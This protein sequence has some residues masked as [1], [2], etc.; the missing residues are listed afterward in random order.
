MSTTVRRVLLVVGLVVLPWVVVP[1]LLARRLLTADEDLT[2]YDRDEVELMEPPGPHG[3]AHLAAVR[4]LRSAHDGFA[5]SGSPSSSARVA[6]VREWMDSLGR[7]VESDAEIRAVDADGVRGEW[8]LAPGHDPDVRLL[9]VHGGAFQAGT[10][11]S[12]RGL[13]TA[14]AERTGASVLAVEYRLQPE[15]RRRAAVHDV[16]AAWRW[17]I[18]TGPAAPGPAERATAAGDSAGANLVLGLLQHLRDTG[19]RQA[20]AA[21]VFAPSTDVTLSGPSWTENIASDAFLGPSF[22]RLMA[23]PRTVLLLAIWM[24][25]GYRP[26]DP[27]VSPLLGDLRQLPPTLVQASDSEMLRDD[28]IR[29][30]TKAREAGSPAELQLW[31][32]MIH[33]F[34]AFGDIPQAQRALD[35]AARFLTGDAVATSSPVRTSG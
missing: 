15:H 29:Y 2:R 14:L 25:S 31:P 8:V 19:G 35:E 26:T 33:V 3:E 17:M 1:W 11:L 22:G 16:R 23:L 32:G 20:D 24:T 27:T 5:T 21:A 6:A 30:A 4:R 7:D 18:A 10:P 34:Q 13:T 9:Y 28:A 12:H